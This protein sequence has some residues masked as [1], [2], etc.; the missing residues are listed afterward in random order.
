M[1]WD[2]PLLK[3]YRSAVNGDERPRVCIAILDCT[4]D[5]ATFHHLSSRDCVVA[6]LTLYCHKHK[7]SD[8]VAVTEIK[9]YS[10]QLKRIQ[11]NIRSSRILI[12]TDTNSRSPLWGSGE[13]DNS[14]ALLEEFLVE[15]GW[16]VANERGGP[17][18]YENPAGD[19]SSI[20]ATF[21]SPGL[22]NI[23]HE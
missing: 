8:V 14:G 4:I 6:D 5:A 13:T 12:G 3:C 2:Q 17:P 15:T 1:V 7:N 20:D 9:V 16:L 18:T 11:L 19:K 23:A 22:Y 10:R 21:M